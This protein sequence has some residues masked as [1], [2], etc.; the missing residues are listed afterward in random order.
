MND[1]NQKSWKQR[2]KFVVKLVI[3]MLVVWGIYRAGRNA[4]NEWSRRT[5]ELKDKV[6]QLE[7]SIS[8][9]ERGSTDALV[10]EAELQQTN[11][12]LGSLSQ[13][14]LGWLAVAGVLYILGL[15]PSWWFWHRA[16]IEMGQAPSPQQ[17]LWAYFLG[18]LGK[19]VPG[20]AMVVI[21]RSTA[22]SGEKVRTSAA[23]L[24]V[25]VETLTMIVVG[26]CV[27]ALILAIVAKQ[28]WLSLL[29]SGI[30]IVA[31]IPL[32]P[33]VFQRLIRVAGKRSITQDLEKWIGALDHRFLVGGWLSIGLGWFLLGGSL[34]ATMRALPAVELS[35]IATSWLIATGCA[36][37]ALVGGFVSLLP[38]GL[39]VR[40]WVVMAVLTPRYGPIAGFA[41]AGL[42]RLVW[43]TSE[44]VVC[45]VLWLA[46][47]RR[48]E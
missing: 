34:W 48:K 6:A 29:A 42:L 18:H 12:E 40:E 38:G 39:G 20:K 32:A 1:T 26:G 4:A 8:K 28:L 3:L 44:L 14:S 45:A 11:K 13:V 41:A 30:V 35:D 27:G 7:T 46:G 36:A 33:A 21:L 10:L 47:F 25:F 5:S 9:A 31:S 43:L 15:L 24:A 37:V 2:T 23:A 16:M 22:V 19:Y 17:S